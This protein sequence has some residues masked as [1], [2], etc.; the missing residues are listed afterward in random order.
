MS[1][2]LPAGGPSRMSVSTTSAS[3]IS[4]IRCA[5]VDPTNPPPS[6]VT[7]F[8]LMPL[9]VPN[10]ILLLADH[11]G[12]LHIFDDCGRKG[13]GA[14][15]RRAWHQAFEIVCHTFLLNGARDAILD[16]RCRFLPSQ[17]LKHHRARKHHR[18]RIDHV[19]IR[20]LWRGAVRRFKTP[21]P[22]P[23]FEPG[24]MPSPPTCAAHAS[25]K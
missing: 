18:T 10:E 12:A 15:F 7:F 23:I 6:T 4:T 21:K 20:V 14:H 2:A 16:Q 19:L 5:V 17:K 3:S 24:A 22:S 25:D 8:L 13:G 9:L 11:G 1:S